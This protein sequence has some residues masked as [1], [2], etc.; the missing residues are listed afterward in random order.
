[1]PAGG[2]N[3]AG[4]IWGL[5]GGGGMGGAVVL[6][7]DR[8]ESI[9]ALG[10]ELSVPL[11]EVFPI[12]D[13][14]E[15]NIEGQVSS[16][17]AGTLVI[18]GAAFTIPSNTLAIVRSVTIYVQNMLATT[19]VTFTLFV[20]TSPVPGYQGLTIFPGASPRIS[21]TFDSFIRI[22]G[23]ANISAQATNIDGGAYLLGLAF[24]GWYWPITSD[25]RWKQRGPT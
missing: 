5:G 11:P 16:P 14:T 2:V 7:P 1:M 9:R 21:N 19:N 3:V 20:N 24:S 13:A 8:A 4:P 12:P 18:T 10:L 6:P 25:G 17:G 23:P 15:F 22:I